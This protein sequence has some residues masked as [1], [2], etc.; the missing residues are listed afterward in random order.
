M[1][2]S[3]F[4]KL[5][6]HSITKSLFSIFEKEGKEIRLVGGCVRDALLFSESKDIDVAAKFQ[7]IEIINVLNKNK[8]EY[9]D[10]GYQYGSVI[11]YLDDY[12]IQITSLR[13]DINQVGRHTDIIYTND[14]KKDAIRRDFTMNALYLSSDG[15]IEDLFSGIKDIEQKTVRFIGHIEESIQEDYLR[16]FRYFRFLGLFDSPNHIDNYKDI[17]NNYITHCFNY[18]SNDIVRQEILKMFNMPYSMNC[19]FQPQQ[20]QVKYKWVEVIKDHFI[21]TNYEIGLNKCLNKIDNIVN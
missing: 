20:K 10:Y 7:P 13:E 18:L 4:D 6:N 8:I 19:F 16:I 15:V 1:P 14:W 3:Q 21:Q 12:K 2:N 9:E 11:A 17:F 5:L